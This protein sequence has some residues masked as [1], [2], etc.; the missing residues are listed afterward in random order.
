ML[1]P[2]VTAA[3]TIKSAVIQKNKTTQN[4]EM[5]EQQGKCN[6]NKLVRKF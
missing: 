1:T 2:A 5:T 4:N 6:S 3:F